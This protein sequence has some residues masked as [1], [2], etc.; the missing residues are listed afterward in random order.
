MRGAESLP[1]DIERTVEDV[2]T[3]E[4]Q[5]AFRKGCSASFSMLYSDV[6]I[7]VC[8]AELSVEVATDIATGKRERR[9]AC[10]IPL[11][12]R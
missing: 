10:W 12:V 6:E 1:Q 7:L 8:A 11:R 9:R 5:A 2:K 4:G 3:S